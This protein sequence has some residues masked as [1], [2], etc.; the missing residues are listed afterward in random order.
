[1]ADT[2]SRFQLQL[3]WD[4]TRAS[5]TQRAPLHPPGIA[6]LHPMGKA[7][8]LSYAEILVSC[9]KTP[10]RVCRIRRSIVLKTCHSDA[11]VPCNID[12][13]SIT[14]KQSRGG[15]T[16]LQDL[17]VDLHRGIGDYSTQEATDSPI[18]QELNPVMLASQIDGLDHSITP[19]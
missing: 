6:A 10:R 15:T 5:D 8:N 18:S 3:M 1:M 9:L 17:I 14:R 7:L 2:I 19:V 16:L 12:L 4:A 13:V 11:R